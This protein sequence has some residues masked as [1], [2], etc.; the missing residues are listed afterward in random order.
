MIKRYVTSAAVVFAL[1][2]A[3]ATSAE[4]QDLRPDRTFFVKPQIGVSHYLGDNKQT[5]FSGEEYD[6]DG[7][8]PYAV[9]IGL[10]YQFSVPFSLNLDYRFADYPVITQFDGETGSERGIDNDPTTRSSI[11][12]TGQ[13]NFANAESRVAPYLK[14]GAN[15]TFGETRHSTDSRLTAVEAQRIT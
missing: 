4:A 1:L 5:L 9:G 6:I 12:L 3:V 10:G 13:Y 15:V 14:L 2:F 7:K 8:F 11:M